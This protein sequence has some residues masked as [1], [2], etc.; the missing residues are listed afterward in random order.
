MRLGLPENAREA[1]QFLLLGA[2]IVLALRLLWALPAAFPSA[3]DVEPLARAWAPFAAAYPLLPHGTMAVEDLEPLPRIAI[4]VL[5]TLICGAVMAVMGAIIAGA[6]RQDAL[7][8]SVLTGRTGLILGGMWGLWCLL[9]V[10]VASS[11]V[12]T[13][14][15]HLKG[16]RSFLGSLPLPLTASEEVIPW[17]EIEG[18]HV[19]DKNTVKGCGTAFEVLAR[20]KGVERPIAAQPAGMGDCDRTLA[21]QRREALIIAQE[22]SAFQR[23]RP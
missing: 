19:L 18:I 21:R 5:F 12:E 8:A 15:L 11:T 22:I 2:G 10:P 9:A 6:A 13:D 4:A 20:A 3:P 16:H 1:F 17:N 14:G 23:Q 7:R